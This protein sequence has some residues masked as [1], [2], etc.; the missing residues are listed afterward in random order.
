MTVMRQGDR[1]GPRPFTQ[2]DGARVRHD[3]HYLYANAEPDRP[4]DFV[5]PRA[6]A[7]HR[8]AVAGMTFNQASL[9]FKNRASSLPRHVS[10]NSAFHSPIQRR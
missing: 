9:G 3:Q 2:D 6:A 7:R 8:A 10:R 5:E 1:D 4:A